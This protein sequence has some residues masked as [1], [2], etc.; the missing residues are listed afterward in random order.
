M[1]DHTEESGEPHSYGMS[2]G[3]AMVLLFNEESERQWELVEAADIDS[4]K[5]WL[6]VFLDWPR[7]LGFLKRTSTSRSV[8]SRQRSIQ[9]IASIGREA[10]DQA[11]WRR[12][13]AVQTARW[14]SLTNGGLQRP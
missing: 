14:R 11:R 9:T 2:D 10:A 3:R 12:V 6:V 7:W 5:I 8:R 1:R 13:P 4:V